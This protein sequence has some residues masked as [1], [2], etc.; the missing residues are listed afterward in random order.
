M[1]PRQRK[2]T[3]AK[4]A[5]KPAQPAVETPVET[6]PEGTPVM[7]DDVPLP[8]DGGGA[9]EPAPAEG[10]H[11][12]VPADDPLATDTVKREPE[13]V[14]GWV[15]PAD[16]DL[17]EGEG[18]PTPGELLGMPPADP[19]IEPQEPAEPIDRSGWQLESRVNL[20]APHAVRGDLARQLL[21]AADRLGYPV[22]AVKSITQGFRVPLDLYRYLFPSGQLE[23]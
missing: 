23:E 7:P 11:T 14:G 18:L 2:T 1:P 5:A 22:D 19:V 17:P 9:G 8:V 13:L 4:T 16:Y 20:H 3:P 12:S 15:A 21:V 6:A 10:S